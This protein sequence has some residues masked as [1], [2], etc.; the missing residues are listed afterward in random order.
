MKIENYIFNTI[1][2]KEIKKEERKLRDKYKK[3]TNKISEK[4]YQ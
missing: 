1:K 4:L 2:Y 3:I